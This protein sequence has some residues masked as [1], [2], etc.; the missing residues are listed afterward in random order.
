MCHHYCVDIFIASFI[1]A[2]K[3]LNKLISSVKQKGNRKKER[4]EK[5]QQFSF[6][7]I[8]LTLVPLLFFKLIVA[9]GLNLIFNF[10]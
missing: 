6:F 3:I 7:F 5:F 8:I 4:K 1:T 9:L 2:T 10:I